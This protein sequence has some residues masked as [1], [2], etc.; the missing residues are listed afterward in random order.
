MKRSRLNVRIALLALAICFP[1]SRTSAQTPATWGIAPAPLFVV[2][3]SDAPSETFTRIGGAVRLR[4][5]RFVVADERDL[6]VSVYDTRGKQLT[7]FGRNGSGPGEFR[8]LGG[9]W[10]AGGDTIVS[11]DSRLRRLTRFLPDGT[12]AGTHV[13]QLQGDASPAEG[14]LDA[15]MGGFPDGRVVLAWIAADRSQE[16]RLAADRMTFGVFSP[17]GEF[18]RILG[19]HSGMVRTMVAQSGGPI[20]FSPFPYAGV[21]GDNFAYTNGAEGEVL[22][23]D[24]R[25]TTR[26]APRRLTVSAQPAALNAAWRAFDDAARNAE[27]TGP[28]L[29]LARSMDRSVGGVPHFARMFADDAG[30]LWLKEYDPRSDAMPLR[31]SQLVTGGRYRVVRADGTVV[32]SIAMRE[33]VAPIAVYGDQLLAVV[34]DEFDVEQFAVYRIVR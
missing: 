13:V 31:G 30:R 7:R 2:G 26:T 28:M 21:S 19:A 14:R 17:R 9:I 5:G 15:F 23:F 1:L 6:R 3:G 16:N 24:A 29:V 32:A 18:Q 25:G 8:S 11:W 12:V 4:D 22:L 10:L 27:V 33:R 20:V 34:R